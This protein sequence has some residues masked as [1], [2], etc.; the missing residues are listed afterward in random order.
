M[1]A[2]LERPSGPK[3]GPVLGHLRA[4]QR[5]P[6]G[7]LERTAREFGDIAYL[8]FAIQ[9]LYLVNHPDL[10]RDV[11]V[12]HASN[13]IKGRM[14]H[15]SKVLLG[16]GLLTSEGEFHLRQRRLVQ[17][18]FYRERLAGYACVMTEYAAAAAARW[19]DGETLDIDREM[20]RLTLGVVARTLFG[21]DVESESGEIGEALTTI[22]GMFNTLMLPFADVLIR[23]PL[24]ASRRFEKARARLDATIYRMI[25][26]RRASGSDHGDLLSMLLAARD[27]EAGGSG[28]TDT[29]VLDES[30]TLFL[31][32][33][34]TT[35]N[36]LTW[37][38]YLLSQNPDVEERLHRE[39]DTILEGRDPQFED[40]PRLAYTE[41]VLAE[42]MRLYPPAWAVGRRAIAE[43]EAGGF[44]VEP[45]AVLVMSPWVMH[46]DPRYYPDPERFD[47]ERWN[48]EAREGRPKFSYFPFGGGPRV[49]IGE[50]FAWIEEMLRGVAGLP[51]DCTS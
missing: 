35:A 28:M 47:P 33:H 26:E 41:K 6:L 44:R 2:V 5:D 16:E 11:L 36:M 38:W 21:A 12:T 43:Y 15:R 39:V 19:R 9:D 30:L 42:S 4:F 29:Q 48:P 31:A 49:C 22:L 34:E 46:R 10:I 17:P 32:G 13:F 40:A 51:L 27:E 50:R 45:G 20:M 1:A 14:L 7:L 8:R 18:A 24:P 25:A 37:T 3:G 23:L